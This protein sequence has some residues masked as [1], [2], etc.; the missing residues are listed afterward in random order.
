MP[1]SSVLEKEGETVPW[2]FRDSVLNRARR[3]SIE[4]KQLASKNMIIPEEIGDHVL[5]QNQ[6]AETIHGAQK[7]S[8]IGS[9][10]AEKLLRSALESERKLYYIFKVLSFS[11]SK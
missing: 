11:F 2:L 10:A 9:D 8:Q 3:N 4:A 5:P 7:Y 6:T 1:H